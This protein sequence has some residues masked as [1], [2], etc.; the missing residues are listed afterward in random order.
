MIIELYQSN[1]IL[2]Q[3]QLTLL[4]FQQKV[5]YMEMAIINKLFVI[6]EQ[7]DEQTSIVTYKHLDPDILKLTF[8][9]KNQLYNLRQSE[10]N[11]KTVFLINPVLLKVDLI[12]YP[13]GQSLKEYRVL[14]INSKSYSIL[15]QNFQIFGFN[16]NNNLIISINTCQINILD[17]EQGWQLDNIQ[18]LPATISEN[19]NFMDL[20]LVGNP[21]ANEVFTFEAVC[22]FSNTT[23]VFQQDIKLFKCQLGEYFN[24]NKCKKCDI[25]RGFYS[26]QKRSQR[27]KSVNYEIIEQ[28]NHGLIKLKSGHW[29]PHY[30]NDQIEI[31]NQNSQNCIGGW[32]VGF[33][34]CQI[35]Y[36]GALCQECDLQNIRGDGHYGKLQQ[37]CYLCHFSFGII[38]KVFFFVL[39]QLITII[40]ATRSQYMIC[41]R[42]QNLIVSNKFYR[43]LNKLSIDQPSV[44]IKQI[45]NYFFYIQFISQSFKIDL[46]VESLVKIISNPISLANPHYDCMVKNFETPELITK[47]II[48]VI[49]P[50]LI[51]I[52]FYILFLMINSYL[53]LK[54]I[55]IFIFLPLEL[56]FIIYS[57][58]IFQFV[59]GLITHVKI[60]G[61]LWIQTYRSIEYYNKN[62][63]PLFIIIA[64]IILILII[65][66]PLFILIILQL[67]KNQLLEKN[68]IIK[69][70]YLYQEYQVK[71]YYWE[72]IKM[73]L[74]VIF[75]TQTMLLLNASDIKYIV[76]VLLIVFQSEIIKQF[77]PY[78]LKNLNQYD[79]KFHLLLLVTTLNFI[80][81]HLS[82]DYQ[83]IILT[84]ILYLVNFMINKYIQGNPILFDKLKLLVSKNSSE[85]DSYQMRKSQT[86]KRFLMMKRY[87]KSQT[88]Y[89]INQ[90]QYTQMQQMIKS[91]AFSNLSEGVNQEL[92]L[93][94]IPQ[95]ETSKRNKQSR[96]IQQN[97]FQ[98]NEIELQYIPPNIK[99]ISIED[100]PQSNDNQL[101]E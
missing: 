39:F 30:S 34:S 79:R 9:N 13:S 10:I 52:L 57:I 70:G 48:Q 2:N 74:K 26:V 94:P 75:T 65:I 50:S 32:D 58:G 91:N 15:L 86:K 59:I 85:N 21:Y 45:Q 101:P 6:K 31:C 33:A 95:K 47:I 7:Y 78:Y 93:I 88:S 3:R 76:T 98:N 49:T 28:L 17:K 12:Y 92:E 41:Q 43:I 90:Q 53:K 44:L 16:I 61:I 77:Q 69:F 36:L 81:V 46:Q 19:Q 66:I 40:I 18:V 84:L 67:R 27:C 71:I 89:K 97:Q 63:I 100:L 68:W 56:L 25:D 73:G 55:F 23:L 72:F 60:S 62:N 82:N 22:N 8:T 42:Y 14:I 51:L 4:Y 80:L 99:Q 96:I 20:I 37:N 38:F 29:R 1:Q 83:Q 64:V 5:S 54:F 87:A 35:G 24:E 11:N